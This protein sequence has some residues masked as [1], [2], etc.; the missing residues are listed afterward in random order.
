M[1]DKLALIR[2]LV[3]NQADHDAIQVFTGHHPKKPP[4]RGAGRTSVQPSPVCK[5]GTTATP[6]FVSLCYPCTPSAI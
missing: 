6:P 1:A 2:S 5:D 3:G 4:P